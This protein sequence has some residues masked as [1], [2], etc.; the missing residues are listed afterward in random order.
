MKKYLLL[1]VPFLGLGACVDTPTVA[2]GTAA[3]AP[4]FS[5]WGVDN[6]GDGIDDGIEMD[7]A[8]QYA[9]VLYMPNLI[10]RAEAGWGISG[11][12]TWPATVSWYLPQVRM[13]MHHN[14]CPDHQMLD[15][16]QVNTTSM[17]Q[18][19]HRRYLRKWYGGC[20]HEGSYLYSN[21]DWHDD[22]HYFLQAGNDDVVHPGIRDPAQWRGYFHAYPNSIGGVSIQYWIFYPYNDFVGG[23]NHEGDWEHINVRLNASQQVDGVWYAQHNGIT[24]YYPWDISWYGSHPQVWVADGS[25]ASYRSESECDALIEGAD[26]SCWTN[27]SQRWF[28]WGGDSWSSDAGI[29]GGALINMGEMPNG[30]SHQPISGQEWIRYSGRWGEKGSTAH[31]NGPRGPG[32]QDNWRKDWPYTGGTGGGGGGGECTGSE[33]QTAGPGG[34][35]EI[36]PC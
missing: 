31:T 7:L 28:T 27:Y 3:D 35:I 20:E 8:D 18:Q 12:W 4:S 5:V 29:R 10:S 32:Y 6:D 25:H 14:N 26:D 2:P 17:L 1:L 15:F 21:R 24:F 23:F 34:N 16:G 11:D 9:P 36:Q 33:E 13:R 22:D 19:A 30:G